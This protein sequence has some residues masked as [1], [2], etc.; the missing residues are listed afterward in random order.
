MSLLSKGIFSAL[1]ILCLSINA[2]AEQQL[3]ASW[4]SRESLIKEGTWKNGKERM[5]ANGEKFNDLLFTCATR[6]FPLGA[7]LKITNPQNNK[8]VIVK[9]TDRIGKRFAK[10]RIDLSKSAFMA[11]ADCK[12]GLVKVKVEII[13]EI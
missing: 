7:Q 10:T 5:M 11:I 8:S 1:I 4:Y 2:F 13:N 12:Q 6:L 9:V 3:L